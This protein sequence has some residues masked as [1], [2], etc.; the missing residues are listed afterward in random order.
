MHVTAE[1]IARFT[2]TPVRTVQRRLAAWRREGGPVV[3]APRSGRGQPPWSVSLDDYCAWRGVDREDVL[4]AL[5]PSAQ[6]AA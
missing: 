6:Q 3:R 1:D 2:G 5:T 4:E